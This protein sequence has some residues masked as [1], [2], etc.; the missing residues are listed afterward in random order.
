MKTNQIVKIKSLEIYQPEQPLKMNKKK[1]K[2][3]LLK[4]YSFLLF[5]KIIIFYF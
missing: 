2:T 5:L 4:Q 1:M 3:G